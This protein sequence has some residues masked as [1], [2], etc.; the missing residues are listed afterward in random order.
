MEESDEEIEVLRK[1]LE[2]LL[3]DQV[4]QVLDEVHETLVECCRRF[5]IKA[6]PDFTFENEEEVTLNR[7][8][9]GDNSLVHSQRILMSSPNG[10]INQVKCVIT[11]LGDSICDADITFKH[12]QGKDNSQFRTGFGQER[13]WKLQQIQDASNFLYT[14][15]LRVEGQDKDHTYKTAKEVILVGYLDHTYKTAK[16]VIPVG[17]LDHTYKTAKE[18]ILV[19]YLDHTYKTAKEVIPV[20]Y[21]DHTYKTAKEVIP[22]GYLDHTYKT[23]KEVIPV[24]YLDHTYKTAKEVIPVGYL[25]HTYKTAKEVIPIL[26]EVMKNLSQGRSCLAFPKRKSLDELVNNV[27]MQMLYPHVPNDVAL[28]FYVHSSKLV[29]AL[30]HLHVNGQQ[31]VDI[32]SR[33]Q[34]ECTIQWLNEAVMLF[35]LAL[36]QCQQLKDKIVVLQQYEKVL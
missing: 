29:L 16:E 27:N 2:W 28:S 19:G 1:E 10:G 33:N 6:S 4:H 13:V 3:Q 30:Y 12:K 14:A 34:V 17:Y 20:G 7:R 31:R 15:R 25:D 35:T 32:T 11:L 8:D 5:L 9:G 18:V 22:V 23:A 21:L 36:Q 26:D 24:G